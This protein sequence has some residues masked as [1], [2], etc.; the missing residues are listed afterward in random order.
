MPSSY[1]QLI[2]T[3]DAQL[4]IGPRGIG[5]TTLLKMLLPEALD[6]WESPDAKM[7]RNQIAFTGVFLQADRIWSGQFNQMSASLDQRFG[8]PGISS[9]DYVHR[10][11]FAIA[12]FA[13][14]ALSAFA[15]AGAYRSRPEG[16][17]SRFRW[18]P[19][20]RSQ[21]EHLI[22]EV[23]PSWLAHPATSTFTGLA[24]QMRH[25]LS[26]LAQ[27][28]ARAGNPSVGKSE[29][30]EIVGDKLLSVD[31][32]TAAV[33]FIDAF[34]HLAGERHASWVLLID[35]FEFLPPAARVQIGEGFQGGD[36]RLSFKV[37]LAP[38]TGTDPFRGT[39]L[40]D[41]HKVELAH[42]PADDFTRRL[43]TRE[44]ASIG[45]PEKILK[46]RGFEPARKDTFAKAS[47]N[48]SD[49][50]RLAALDAGFG[51]WLAKT[52]GGEDLDALRAQDPRYRTL[53]RAMPL[54]R[55]RLEGRRSQSAAQEEQAS[56]R[57]S[58]L[59]AG[60]KNAYLLTE[61]NP[62][63]IKALA[64]ELHKRAGRTGT[65]SPARQAE[66]ISHIARILHD[67]LQ[68]VS[69]QQRS[70]IEPYAIS[71][72]SVRASGERS[73]LTPFGL[74]TRLGEYLHYQTHDARFEAE[75]AGVFRIDDQDPWLVDVLNSL[76]FLGA[77]VVEPRRPGAKYAQVRLAHMWAP[78]FELLVS[79]GRLRAISKVLAADPPPAARA[80]GNSQEALG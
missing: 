75:V 57:V 67:N 39:E 54:V 43:F 64:Y 22:G 31:F 59:Y 44:L 74:L 62:R 16:E 17:A 76:I 42:D 9:A 7:A 66:A 72:G 53:R 41:W 18:V 36:P 45:R 37:S 77:L 69:I 61:G 24:G 2:G 26:M 10:R 11:R 15:E 47:R 78:L 13:Y 60:A 35:E 25:N 79:R 50:R 33:E 28:I 6:A 65:I 58:E 23:A 4:L 27:L 30:A 5:K 3:V 73:N 14:L 40:N 46:G 20:S 48:A 49:I 32:A 19:I 29:L 34:N 71:P 8:A 68:A 55:L 38:Y 80:H 56:R 63:W 52:L 70:E 21:E 51:K 12:A 1:R